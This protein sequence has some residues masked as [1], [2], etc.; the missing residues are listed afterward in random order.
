M[1]IKVKDNGVGIP[2]AIKEKIMQ[3]FFTTKP[4]GEGTGLGLSLTYDMVVKGHG[5]KIEVN[6]KRGEYTGI[7]LFH[8]LF[9]YK[10]KRYIITT[11]IIISCLPHCLGQ[12]TAGLLTKQKQLLAQASSDTSRIR[13][14]LEV[15]AD[16]RFSKVDSALFYYNKAISFAQ[17]TKSL[18]LEARALSDKGSILMDSGDI[19]QAYI[20]MLQSLDIIKKGTR[21]DKP[22]NFIHAAVENRLGNLFMELGEYKTSIGHYRIGMLYYNRSF[23][24]PI[25]NCLSNI[26]N[27]FELAWD[28]WIRHRSASNGLLR[29]Y[30]TRQYN[31]F[32]CF[33]G[34]AGAAW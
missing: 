3:P 20:Y 18:E 21:D 14:L 7:I 6:T 22:T 27:D 24:K 26:G 28:N 30:K 31:Y 1:I 32:C 2:D 17:K 15:G 5:G 34:T 12:V 19:P 23:R 16:Y 29:S 8:C 11:A 9:L 33:C 10:M 4:T 25:Y 13:L